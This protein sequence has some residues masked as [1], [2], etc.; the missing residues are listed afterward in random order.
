MSLPDSQAP[1]LFRENQVKIPLL[2]S[3]QCLSSRRVH[4]T[5]KPRTA[6]AGRRLDTT[7]RHAAV[8]LRLHRNYREIAIMKTMRTTILG[9]LATVFLALALPASAADK[10]FL[11]KATVYT[12]TGSTVI[13]LG[14]NLPQGSATKIL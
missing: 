2:L 13:S 3:L 10:L 4:R 5:T 12:L 9:F 14:N 7:R 6:L 8:A 11:V 1:D